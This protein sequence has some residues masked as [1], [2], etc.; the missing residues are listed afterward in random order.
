[1]HAAATKKKK[2]LIITAKLIVGGVERALLELLNNIDME[3]YSV[4]LLLT[5]RGGEL[6]HFISSDVEIRYLSIDMSKYRRDLIRRFQWIQLIRSSY[7]RISTHFITDYCGNT[8]NAVKSWPDYVDEYDYVIAYKADDAL[9]A[10]LPSKFKAKQ[11]ILWVHAK[12]PDQKKFHLWYKK[13]IKE[14]SRVICVSNSIKHHVEELFCNVNKQNIS[15]IHNLFD[16]NGILLKSNDDNL[17]VMASSSIVTVGR[18]SPE[19]G[20]QMIPAATRMLLDAGH[21]VYWYL[22]GD[23]SLRDEIE[24]ECERY[25]VEDHVILLGTQMNPYPYIKG[26]DIYVQPSFTEGYCTTTVEAKILHKP[27]VT[28]DAPGMREQFK[29]GENG[30][31]VDAMT[32]EALFEGIKTLLEAPELCRKFTENLKKESFDNDSELQKLYD[33]IEN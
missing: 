22:V 29:S 25:G 23:G 4:T 33:L 19:K 28:T 14:F 10:S 18:L 15:V 31:I 11:K 17:P 24:R 12:F 9:V 5:K 32:P 6:E 21:D 30:L 1:M 3:S 2:I 7:Y 26:C 8:Y 27:I 13:I 20:Q 16:I